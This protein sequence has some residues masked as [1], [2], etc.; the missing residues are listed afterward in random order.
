M[1]AGKAAHRISLAQARRIA[2]DSA[3]LGPR[4]GLG[5][6]TGAVLETV[7]RLGYVQIDSISVVNR[8]H[9]HT[10]WSRV[11]AYSDGAL[12]PLLKQRQLFEYWG[13]A[14][15]FLPMEDY[16]FYLPLARSYRERPGIPF[17]RSL[18]KHEALFPAILERIEQ[19]G[20]MSSADFGDEHGSRGGSWWDWKPAK[21][22]LELLT[23]LGELMVSERRGFQR[24]YDL[25]DRVLPDGLDRTE[26][27]ED[28]LAEFIVRRTIGAY[29]IAREREVREMLRTSRL[30]PVKEKLASMQA[31]GNIVAIEVEGL[32]GHTW[33]AFPE[34]LEGL[35]AYRRRREQVSILSP[36]D[37]LVILRD[38]LQV[39]FG[40]DY[41][42][43]CYVPQPKRQYG[44]FSLPLLF[45]ERFVGRLDAKAR[46][47]EKLLE[48]QSLHLEDGFQA[49]AEF[50]TELAATLRGFAGFN[51]CDAVQL[52]GRGINVT[53]ALQKRIASQL[54]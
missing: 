4:K 40:Y 25:R 19:Q 28:E 8:A 52:S 16:R 37:N 24:I 22:A 17:A 46:R 38:R 44:Y 18:R 42:I 45:G 30:V 9:H 12:Y 7:R 14:A 51:D 15:S 21:S 34:L 10:T 32:V 49:T 29:G 1:T 35:P 33:Y 6:G 20:P 26:P 41:L 31:K 53:A 23:S 5:K 39:L 2:V 11:P 36:F 50:E 47:R 54:G 13:H 48:V 3:L 27:D 43:E